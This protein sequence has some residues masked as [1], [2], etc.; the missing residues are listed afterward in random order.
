MPHSIILLP[1]FSP[2]CCYQQIEGS[3][4]K[5][6]LIEIKKKTARLLDCSDK[7]SLLSRPRK[8]NECRL[9]LTTDHC[10]VNFP[11]HSGLSEKTPNFHDNIPLDSSILIND[12]GYHTT[13]RTRFSQNSSNTSH[14]NSTLYL[15]NQCNWK[16]TYIS[17]IWCAFD[18]CTLCTPVKIISSLKV[19]NLNGLHEYII[20]EDAHT[21]VAVFHYYH[22]LSCRTCSW[23]EIKTELGWQKH[24][25]NYSLDHVKTIPNTH[26]N[27]KRDEVVS[28]ESPRLMSGKIYEI[29]NC[30]IRKTN[31]QHFYQ[32]HRKG[33]MEWKITALKDS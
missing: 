6:G 1:I 21:M 33:L 28:V 23:A 11:L 19:I 30:A 2:D 26:R 31:I 8:P 17:Y 3:P 5:T 18:T 9:S 4:R 24:G 7:K 29:S 27:G 25:F 22:E 13:Q 15:C 14:V 16:S 10:D 32:G 12:C 20:N